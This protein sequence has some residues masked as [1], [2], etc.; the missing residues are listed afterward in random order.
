[1][2]H[3][4]LRRKPG[5]AIV[6]NGVIEITII[7]IEGDR[8]KLSIR[9]PEDVQIVRKELLDEDHRRHNPP[10]LPPKDAA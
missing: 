3:L 7:A 2:G 1:M 8:C 5:Q 9:A 6:L 10:P 4:V